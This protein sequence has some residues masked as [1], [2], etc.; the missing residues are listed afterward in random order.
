MS[1]IEEDWKKLKLQNQ[2]INT[3]SDASS[4]LNKYDLPLN[5]DGTLSF[6]WFDAH[7]EKFGSDIFL[8]GKVW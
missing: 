3:A 2:T 7:E 6:F 5:Q 4:A 1:N 8:F